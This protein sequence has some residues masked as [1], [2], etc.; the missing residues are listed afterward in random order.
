LPG[1][2]DPAPAPA[3]Q[4]QPRHPAAPQLTETLNALFRKVAPDRQRILP[5]ELDAP[6]LTR[7]IGR[8]VS[9]VLET[10]R[11][12]PEVQ[13]SE[14][15]QVA[16]DIVSSLRFAE[17]LNQCTA[18][19]QLPVQIG[20][21]KTTAQLYVFNDSKNTKKKIDPQNATMFVSLATANLGQVEGFVKVIG[22]NVE[23]DFS[24]ADEATSRRFRAALPELSGLLEAQGFRLARVGTNVSSGPPSDPAGVERTHVSRMG[25]YSLDIRV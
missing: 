1:R 15:V 2:A 6:R 7:E 14:V 19:A 16:R 9:D 18:F 23:A 12:L 8:L 24:L 10:A 3:A 21:E 25:R 11:S 22:K 5:R 13:R 4:T 20:K 17:Q